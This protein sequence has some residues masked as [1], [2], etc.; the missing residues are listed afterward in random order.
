MAK[1]TGTEAG[2][3]SVLC[4]ALGCAMLALAG[5]ATIVHG[6]TEQ[7]QIDSN[8]GGADVQIDRSAHVTTPAAVKLSRGSPHQLVFHKPGYQ[9]DTELLTSSPSGWILANLI[10]GG[11]IGIAID[12]ADGAGRKLSSDSVNVTLRPAQATASTALPAA[13]PQAKEPTNLPVSRSSEAPTFRDDTDDE[14]DYR[15]PASAGLQPDGEPYA[16]PPA[17]P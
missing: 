3:T 6:T 17:N 4:G 16:A 5:C 11:A 8:P 7:V 10:G 9:D 1:R 2:A 14:A 15:A 12:A 13:H